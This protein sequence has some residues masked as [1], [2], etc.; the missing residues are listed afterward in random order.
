MVHL[1]SIM[2][3]LPR[4]LQ[5]NK[6]LKGTMVQDTVVC[7][8]CK[9]PRCIY[10]EFAMGSRKYGV[11]KEVQGRCWENLQQWKENGFAC[12]SPPPVQ[13]YIVKQQL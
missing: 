10:S 6:I 7:D 1:L 9:F 2:L 4:V 13:P 12:G 8:E 3:M 5:T 11:R